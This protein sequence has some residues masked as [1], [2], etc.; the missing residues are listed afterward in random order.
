[1]PRVKIS[2]RMQA[3]EIIPKQGGEPFY[4]KLRAEA[5]DD[6]LRKGHP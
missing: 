4:V 2:G 1:M 6:L 3:L 5:D